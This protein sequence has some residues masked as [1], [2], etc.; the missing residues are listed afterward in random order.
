MPPAT[1]PWIDTIVGVLSVALFALGLVGLLTQ[2]EVIRQIFA[3][4]IMLQGVCL[5]LIWAGR[6]NSDVFLAQSMV[7]SA[8]IVEAVVMAVALALMVNVYRHYPSGD[9]DELTRLRG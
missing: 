7:L 3:L 9:V 1:G 5:A 4:K 2:R 8:L 6:A